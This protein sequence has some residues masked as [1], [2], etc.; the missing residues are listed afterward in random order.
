MTIDL[1]GEILCGIKLKWDYDKKTINLS[2][3]NYV[4]K[5]LSHLHNTTPIKPQHYSHLYN[6]PIC[7]HTRQF[8]IP[9]ITNK[10]LTPAQLKHCQE[11]CIYNY[12]YAQ[13][14]DNTMQISI[15]AITSPLST[16]SWKDIKFLI[17]QF[18]GYTATHSNAKIRYHSSQMHL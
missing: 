10:K 17:N 9:T 13:S 15:S 16:R 4:N 14:I 3:P 18:L 7:G 5:S 12:Y 11:F 1:S 2:M 8:S 6:A